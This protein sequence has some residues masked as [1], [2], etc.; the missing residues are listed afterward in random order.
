[1]ADEV[2]S[3]PGAAE[4]TQ[5]AEANSQAEV[6]EVA[7]TPVDKTI[8]YKYNHS[9]EVL[10]LSKSEDMEKAAEYLR[11]GRYFLEKGKEKL[12]SY[13]SDEGYKWLQNV[14]KQYGVKTADLAQKWGPELEERIVNAYADANDIT[15][16]KAK[17]VLTDNVKNSERDKQLDELLEWK[18]RQDAT[19]EDID[20]AIKAGID[21]SNIPEEVLTYAKKHNVSLVVAHD[22]YTGKTK[23]AKIAELEKQLGIKKA[24]DANA[25]SSMGAV[26]GAGTTAEY[27]EEMIKGMTSEQRQANMPGILK[28]MH[29]KK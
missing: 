2:V 27:S 12:S 21:I 15:P 25:D 11:E 10:D 29:R 14:A 5:A 13:E 22:V 16:E 26:T 17:Q 24:N 8:K 19:S 9:E 6:A 18:R 28:W 20:K 23:D 7:A 3:T 4:V 1:M